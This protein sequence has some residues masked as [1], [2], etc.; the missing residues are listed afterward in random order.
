MQPAAT[1]SS[2]ESQSASSWKCT[3]S[4]RDAVHARLGVGEQREQRQ[5]VRARRRRQR[6][7]GE[8]VGAARVGGPACRASVVPMRVRVP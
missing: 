3:S 5:R 4:T 6:R 7:V 1:T 8:L 2:S